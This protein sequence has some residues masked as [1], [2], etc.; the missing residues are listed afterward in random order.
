MTNPD[1]CWYTLHYRPSIKSVNIRSNGFIGLL[2]NDTVITHSD[3]FSSDEVSLTL[4]D[5]SQSGSS[6]PFSSSVRFGSSNVII[7]EIDADE[8]LLGGKRSQLSI[9]FHN[10]VMYSELLKLIENNYSIELAEDPTRYNVGVGLGIA[11]HVLFGLSFVALSLMIMADVENLC[12]LVIIGTTMQRFFMLLLVNSRPSELLAS[13]W[14]HFGV[15]SFKT[16]YFEYLFGLMVDDGDIAMNGHRYKALGWFGFDTT[17]IVSNSAGALSVILVILFLAGSFSFV[18]GVLKL[19]CLKGKCM[20]R[21]VLLLNFTPQILIVV[22]QLV[23]NDLTL[24]VFINMSKLTFNNKTEIFSSCVWLIWAQLIKHF[25]YN[26]NKYYTIL[27][28]YVLN[29]KLKS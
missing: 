3:D 10:K 7:V 21:L 20:D 17:N 14:T 25:L 9:D 6:I 24:S 27:F 22:Q 23:M 1:R 12:V 4:T 15:V 28:C 19:F 8:V 26:L 11:F 13:F 29:Y 5:T 16:V 2:I 18:V